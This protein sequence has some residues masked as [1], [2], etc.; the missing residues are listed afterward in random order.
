MPAERITVTMMR[1]KAVL[2]LFA[3]GMVFGGAKP[4]EAQITKQG[5]GYLFRM[6]FVPNAKASYTVTASNPMSSNPIKMTMTQVIKSVKNGI[7]TIEFKINSTSQGNV[8]RDP[9]TMQMDS[10]GRLVGN[11]AGGM[12][13]M[14]NNIELPQ[15][16]IAIG[17]TWKGEVSG[18]QGMKVSATYKF[19][20]IKKIGNFDCAQ[21][22][23]SSTGGM[24]QMKMNGTGTVYMRL[25]DGSAQSMNMSMNMTMT[26]PSDTKGGGKPMNM[27]TTITMVRTG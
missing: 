6:K 24:A 22:A 27:T 10:R 26:P 7:A 9:M 21:V 17:Q 16:P 12:G 11:A 18:A 8:P 4:A 5:A 3:A 1:Y 13:S 14:G 15:G 2:V 23:V 19:V 20:G 25:A